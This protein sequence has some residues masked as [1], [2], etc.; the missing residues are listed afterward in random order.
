MGYKALNEIRKYYKRL[1]GV[2]RGYTR[3]QGITRGYRKLQGVTGGYKG[4]QEVTGGYNGLEKVKRDY[5]GLQEVTFDWSLYRIHKLHVEPPCTVS[6]ACEQALH[7]EKSGKVT[8]EQH[9]KG[10]ASVRGEERRESFP[11]FLYFPLFLSVPCWW[12]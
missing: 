9:A 5:K 10:N 11:L 2:T 4:L 8:R 1:Q 6:I 7:E 12:L 3:L